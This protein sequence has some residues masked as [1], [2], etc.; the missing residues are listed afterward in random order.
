[1]EKCPSKVKKVTK[2]LYS[3]VHYRSWNQN[4]GLAQDK[5][6]KQALTK[7]VKTYHKN[8]AHTKI[9]SSKNK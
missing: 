4:Q 5:M 8:L 6:E 2:V 7:E 9:G 3:T 1:L